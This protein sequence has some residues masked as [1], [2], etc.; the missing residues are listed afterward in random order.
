MAFS[1]YLIKLG[2]S[3]G[4]VLPLSYMKL[5]SYKCTPDQRLETE[6]QRTATGL[7]VRTTVDHKPVKIEFETPPMTN[8]EMAALNTMIQS[9]FTNDTERKLTINFYDNETD[10]YRNA[11]CYMPDT[12]YSINRIVGNT[13]YYSSVRFAFIEY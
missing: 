8:R 1:G 10:S 2:G 6:A 7:L 13:I 11:E 5:E 3:S 4:T 12:D 9:A